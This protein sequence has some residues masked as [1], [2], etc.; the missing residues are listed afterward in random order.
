MQINEAKLVYYL[1]I[2]GITQTQ[3][4]VLVGM[5]KNTIYMIKRGRRCKDE[6][7][8]KIAKALGVDVTDIIES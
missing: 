2:K 1:T 4:A 3:L 8:K 5:S 7:G 6:V